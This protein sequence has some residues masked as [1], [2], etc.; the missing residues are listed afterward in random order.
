MRNHLEAK[1][2]SNFRQNTNH[3]MRVIVEGNSPMP[4]THTTGRSSCET[5]SRLYSNFRQNTNCPPTTPT[6]P[7]LGASLVGL[8][9]Q[10][11]ASAVVN[12]KPRQGDAA[13][14]AGIA[15]AYPR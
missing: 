1:L 14:L 9:A 5:T 8:N 4:E 12:A 7:C 10:A 6:K 13:A 2:Y 3:S 11:N 15:P